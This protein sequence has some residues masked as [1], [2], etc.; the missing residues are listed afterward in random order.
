MITNKEINMTDLVKIIEND[1]LESFKK[2]FILENMLILKNKQD[3]L[4]KEIV[5]I[6]H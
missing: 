5:I 6:Y 1:D 2:I 4:K 3:I